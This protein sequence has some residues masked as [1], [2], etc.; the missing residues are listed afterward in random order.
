MTFEQAL[1]RLPRCVRGGLDLMG[2][3]KTVD[4]LRFL[5][6]HEIDLYEE[7][8]IKLTLRKLDSLRRFLEIA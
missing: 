7:G 8:E 4:D 6:Q 5:V 2:Q 3:H 1:R